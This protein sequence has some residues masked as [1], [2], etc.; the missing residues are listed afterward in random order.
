MSLVSVF[1]EGF[2]GQHNTHTHLEMIGIFSLP[3][4][5]KTS[6]KSQNNSTLPDET[7]A[8]G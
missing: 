3:S 4:G 6:H 7:H 2:Q 5:L 1:L 8:G